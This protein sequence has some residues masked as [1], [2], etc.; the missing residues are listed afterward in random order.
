MT[1]TVNDETRRRRT[2][3]VVIGVAFLLLLGVALLFFQS[4]RSSAQAEQRADQLIAELSARGLRTPPQDQIVAVL[5]DDGG[6][7]CSDP[8]SALRHS[9][10]YG[11]LVNGAG[12]PGTRPVIA[13][14]RVLQGQLLIMKVYCPAQ[15]E[16]FT[17]FAD[18]LKLANVA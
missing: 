5:G 15:L 12:G 8:N 10:L 7:V 1:M 16:R 14:N 4:N 9:V 6:A 13:D 17:Q 11:Q 18:D 2:T 3:Y